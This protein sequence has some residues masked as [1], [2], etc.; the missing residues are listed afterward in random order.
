MQ[1]ILAHFS[2]TDLIRSE[3]Q[4]ERE[5][6]LIPGVLKFNRFF[7]MPAALAIQLCVG[8]LYAWSGYNLPIEAAIYGTNLNKGTPVD[9]NIASIT[10]YIAVAVFGSAAAILGP[11]LERHGPFKGT[12]LGASLFYAGN[13][14][15]GLG[16]FTKQMWLV[17]VGYGVVGGMGLGIGYIAPVSP[18]QKF[19]PEMRGI[20]AGLAVCGFGGGSII[21]PFSQL[22]LIGS[23]YTKDLNTVVGVPLT[24]VILGSIY[25]VVMILAGL[26][27]RM[28]PP[29]YQVKGITVHT[30]A[31]AENLKTS[32]AV[33]ES[34]ATLIPEKVKSDVEVA[35]VENKSKDVFSISLPEALTSK[36]FWLMYAMFFGSQMS[37][38]LMISKIQSIV[39]NQLGTDATTAA[40]YNSGL[41]AMNL[42]GRLLLPTISD[43]VGRK[44]LFI[45]SLAVQ[46][47][48]V[49]LLPDFIHLKSFPGVITSAFII[50][51]FYGSGFGMIPAFLADQFSSKNV[52]ATHGVIL[53]SWSLTG[54]AGA[55]IFNTI[56]LSES[57]R[58]Q[59][60]TAE[61]KANLVY[62][63]DANMRWVL[64][65]V[66]ISF[67]VCLFIPVNLRIRK[68]PRVAG[69][70]IRF[71]FINGRMIRVMKGFKF[72]Q[73]SK[74]VEDNEW[75]AYINTLNVK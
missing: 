42:I 23:T 14:L 35:V 74:E 54:V 50:G 49:G 43:F 57:A 34:S 6:W 58:L 9:R 45:L 46:A 66:L 12:L 24:F 7:L 72:V 63:Y 21:A 25:F 41:S 5:Q 59:T 47:I 56:L 29:G 73:V 33:D 48:L 51:L 16:V 44:P 62:I 61:G 71:R 10:F 17:Y 31:G 32:T 28:P 69:E 11:W 8:S 52:G 4:L 60:S 70:I 3:A 30:I 19:F 67:L 13:L 38:L 15:A 64:C 68:L 22:G 1:R 53:T 39:I 27:L 65:I 18:L 55:L 40:Y 26:V 75:E 20:A 2:S 36:E 37:G